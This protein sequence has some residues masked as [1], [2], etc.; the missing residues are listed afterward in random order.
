MRMC[1]CPSVLHDSEKNRPGY[2]HP[3]KSAVVT[4]LM[5]RRGTHEHMNTNTHGWVI[6]EIIDYVLSCF[7]KT[8][9]SLFS[10][11][12]AKMTQRGPFVINQSVCRR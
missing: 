3:E 7:S 9:Y 4:R 8:P 10:S 6:N 12:A 11:A 1:E 2:W 5:Q